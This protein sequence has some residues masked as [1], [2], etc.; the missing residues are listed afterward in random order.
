MK[1]EHTDTFKLPQL[2]SL[3]RL[4][5]RKVLKPLGCPICGYVTETPQP[6]FDEHITQ[7]LHEFAL[8]CLPWSAGSIDGDSID[9]KSARESHLNDDLEADDIEVALP[10]IDPTDPKSLLRA[11]EVFRSPEGTRSLDAEQVYRAI[12]LDNWKEQRSRLLK[13]LLLVDFGA[14]TRH[15]TI[16][17]K[18]Q[19]FAFEELLIDSDSTAKNEK[20]NKS[21][22]LRNFT[23]TSSPG[24]PTSKDA[25]QENLLSR[26]MRILFLLRHA[27]VTWLNSPRDS[28]EL[29][30]EGKRLLESEKREADFNSIDA[31]LILEWQDL[32]LEEKKGYRGNGEKDDMAAL[33]LERLRFKARVFGHIR[34]LLEDEMD[35]ME[36]ACGNAPSAPI[37]QGSGDSHPMK[38][39]P[40]D[41]DT[42]SISK[43]ER[44]NTTDIAL[45]ADE[46]AVESQ[47]ITHPVVMAIIHE[48]VDS[49]FEY[50]PATLES[51]ITR[52]LQRDNSLEGS[53]VQDYLRIYD[54]GGGN[55]EKILQIAR[56][57]QLEERLAYWLELT[58]SALGTD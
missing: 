21:G 43:E 55:A 49:V 13:V 18:Q 41:I 32:G 58:V 19:S 37:S 6:T 8:R 57:E 35:E 50:F 11:I 24:F 33:S 46:G 45:G 39:I 53:A 54:Q 12:W 36:S 3:A 51:E 2:S 17:S 7:H 20:R 42:L 38:Q 16:L 27:M 14:F 15:A 25:L 56:E 44:L 30:R 40:V 31:Q 47:R 1:I 23:N 26:V 9:A 34:V 48:V 52:R 5:H 22:K 28:F 4:S 10:D 29:Y